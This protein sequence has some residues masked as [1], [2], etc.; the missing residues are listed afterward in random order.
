MNCKEIEVGNEEAHQR[1]CN[2]FENRDEE[3][4][5]SDF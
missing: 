5:A 3:E 4:Y 2:L 1:Q